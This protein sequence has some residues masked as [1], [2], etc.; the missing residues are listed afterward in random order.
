MKKYTVIIFIFLTFQNISIATTDTAQTFI[1]K[2]IHQIWLGNRELPKLYKAYSKTWLKHNPG[3]QYKLWTD[4]DVNNW[5]G[6]FYL[7]D[8]YDKAY[9]AQEKADILRFNIIYRYGGVYADTDIEC[10]KS[11]DSLSNQY[12]FFS[13][14]PISVLAS[15]PNNPIFLKVFDRIRKNWHV[16][17]EAFMKKKEVERIHHLVSIATERCQGSFVQVIQENISYMN[18]S[19][20]LPAEQLIYYMNTK[21]Y[22]VLN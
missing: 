18:N 8:L 13:P 5:K 9:T 2:I 15:K 10:L 14:G 22:F 6:K 20:I 16:V 7:K 19:I 3:W 12:D 11:F 17:E 1:P 21:F 4:Q